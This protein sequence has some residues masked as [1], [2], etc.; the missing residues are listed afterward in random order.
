MKYR[1]NAEVVSRNI[2]RGKSAN[3]VSLAIVVV[4]APL[5]T[6]VYWRAP[7]IDQYMRDW[8][9]R[10]RGPLP[11][12]DDI[13]IVAIDEPNQGRIF[14]LGAA[15][16]Q[17]EKDF[18]A[19]P[20]RP[21][22][23]PPMCPSGCP[24]RT[25]SPRRQGFTSHGNSSCS[26]AAPR[27]KRTVS[28]D[29]VQAHRRESDRR[30]DENLCHRERVKENR[31]KLSKLLKLAR[32]AS[33]ELLTVSS[34]RSSGRQKDFRVRFPWGTVLVQK[35]QFS[36]PESFEYHCNASCAKAEDPE[37]A[38]DLACAAAMLAEFPSLVRNG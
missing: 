27:R 26:P 1:L 21:G 15:G 28:R 24:W 5:G 10:A 22:E 7:G 11:A 14:L 6:F 9:I 29:K 18:R 38:R 17:E 3:I 2:V 25:R 33:A 30:W 16:A 13:A 8:I 32:A 37:R 12:P 20:G 19:G 35:Y 31:E 4:S 36:L 23:E 34:V